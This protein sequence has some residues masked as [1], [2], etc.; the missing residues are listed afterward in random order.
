MLQT[1]VLRSETKVEFIMDDIDGILSQF[2]QLLEFIKRCDG[3]CFPIDADFDVRLLYTR[4][5]LEYLELDMTNDIY[6][7][8]KL[9]KKVNETKIT[10]KRELS[11]LEIDI[12]ENCI[13]SS[14]IL[15]R[16]KEMGFE[17]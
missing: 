5:M 11:E 7:V 8:V 16:L 12:L 17:Y 14:K 6:S 4:K 2:L 1:L 10:L 3:F 9:W 15:V 13:R